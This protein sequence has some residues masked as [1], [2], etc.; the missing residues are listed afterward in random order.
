MGGFLFQD[1]RRGDREGQLHQVRARRR[2][3]DQEPG[4]REP[5]VRVE[6]EV[7]V[8]PHGARAH[9]PRHPVRDVQALG[10]DPGGEPVPGVV[11]LLDHLVHRPGVKKNKKPIRVVMMQIQS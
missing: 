6:D 8:H 7:A 11:G 9:R 4:R 1:G 10:H 3:C 2:D 5:G